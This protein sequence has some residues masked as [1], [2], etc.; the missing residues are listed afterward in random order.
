MEKIIDL[1]ELSPIEIAYK[2]SILS[3]AQRQILYYLVRGKDDR[4][5]ATILSISVGLL[6]ARLATGVDNVGL[7]RRS[8][9]VALFA[10]WHYSKQQSNPPILSI[11]S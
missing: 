9:L 3:E 6:R 10:I 7:S 4:T 8:E 5:T 11:K 2:I 1:F